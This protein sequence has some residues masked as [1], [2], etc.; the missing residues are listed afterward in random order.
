MNGKTRCELFRAIRRRMC[1]NNGIEYGEKP[2]PHQNPSCRGTCPLCDKA[3]AD[4]NSR[5]E[6]KRARGENVDFSGIKEI[7][8]SFLANN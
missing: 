7:Y 4:L 1:E 3:L 6:E 2:C 8:A 5:L